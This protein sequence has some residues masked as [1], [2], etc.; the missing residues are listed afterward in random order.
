[1]NNQVIQDAVAEAIQRQPWYEKNANTIVSGLVA[2]LAVLGFVV[3]FEL[4]IRD[5]WA[6]VIPAVIAALTPVAVKLT[7][8]G[9][10]PSTAY[11][12]D[13]TTA[14]LKGSLPLD[15]SSIAAEAA[16][17][18]PAAPNIADAVQGEAQRWLPTGDLGQATGVEASPLG[19]VDEPV[20]YIGQHRGE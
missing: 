10:Q 7:K 18:A 15:T 3:S 6:G 14:A 20:D 8:N 13:N 5:E 2:L 16:R 19:R 17:M 4:P 9:V 12:L 1:M 11:K